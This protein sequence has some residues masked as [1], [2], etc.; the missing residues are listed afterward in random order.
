MSD[1]HANIRWLKASAW[2]RRVASTFQ[3]RRSRGWKRE[4]SVVTDDACGDA[5]ALTLFLRWG[6]S[7][8]ESPR[9]CPMA[10]VIVVIGQIGERRVC[11]ALVVY[12]FWTCF[13]KL[14][15]P[16]IMCTACL[17][18]DWLLDGASPYAFQTSQGERVSLPV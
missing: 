10:H 14:A 16:L 3:E 2:R 9:V 12:G 6:G 13:G 8:M 7:A 11:V 18:G 1:H 5:V 17:V 4:S 15:I